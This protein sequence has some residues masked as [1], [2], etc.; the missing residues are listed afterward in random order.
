MDGKS[1]NVRKIGQQISFRKVRKV[2]RKVRP[3]FRDG[4]GAWQDR[5]VVH[6]ILEAITFQHGHEILFFLDQIRKPVDGNPVFGNG[7][8]EIGPDLSSVFQ[9]DAT[10]QNGFEIPDRSGSPCIRQE[11]LR[12]FHPAGNAGIRFMASRHASTN[13]LTGTI[14]AGEMTVRTT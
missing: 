1:G 11:T 8:R 6:A 14:R 4:S 9:F 10:I 3:F 13:G 2:D 5:S 7:Q 12:T